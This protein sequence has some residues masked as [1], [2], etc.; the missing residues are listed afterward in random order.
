MNEASPLL[1]IAI[2]NLKCFVNGVSDTITSASLSYNSTTNEYQFT[3]TA[4][5]DTNDAVVVQLYDSSNSIAV[6][7]IGQRYYKGAT[8]QFTPVA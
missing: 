5:L 2:A 6:A 7:K 4:T 1:G 3:P 8:A